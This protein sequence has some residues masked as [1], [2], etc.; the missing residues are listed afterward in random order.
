MLEKMKKKKGLFIVFD[1]I[2]GSGKT[3]QVKLL[4]GRLKKEGYGVEKLDFP[5]YGKKSAVLVE[6][7]LNGEFGAA[8][9]VGPY[10]ASIFYA[11]D[12]YAASARIKRW[13]RAGRI[14]VSDR[15]VTANMGHQGGKISSVRERKKFFKWL[16]DLEYNLFSVPK[17]DINVILH[18]DA[19]VAQKLVA[20]TKKRRYIKKGKKDIH[21]SDLRHLRDAEKTYIE[22]A[23]IFSGFSLIECMKNGRIMTRRE[24]SDLIWNKLKKHLATS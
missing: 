11:C 6:E 5:Q 3:T 7:Y 8:K 4:V 24:I 18:V 22:I 14:V 2:D 9:D 1:G 21:E 20:R 16:F 17:P 13:L 10:R 19:A 23:K 15:Y 12:R